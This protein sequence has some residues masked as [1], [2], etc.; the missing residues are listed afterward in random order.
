MNFSIVFYFSFRSVD[1]FHFCL[2]NY[3]VMCNQKQTSIA[4]C[5]NLWN[6]FFCL[7]CLFSSRNSKFVNR[8]RALSNNLEWEKKRVCVIIWCVSKSPPCSFFLLFVLILILKNK[9][10]SFS[11]INLQCACVCVNLSQTKQDR[12]ERNLCGKRKKTKTSESGSNCHS[13]CCC[14]FLSVNFRKIN[15]LNFR[16]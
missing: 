5:L 4:F 3:M 10:Y 12:I 2:Y 11:S 6:E 8:K 1:S 14:C 16:K 7:F 13:F 9:S 15:N